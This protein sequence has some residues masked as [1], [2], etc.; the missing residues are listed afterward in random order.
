[1]LDLASHD[2]LMAVDA[3]FRADMLGCADA[4]S[5]YDAQPMAAL[6]VALCPAGHP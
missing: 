1:M 4:L 5:A 2:A 3:A 6:P